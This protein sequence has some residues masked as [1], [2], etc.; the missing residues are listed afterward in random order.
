MWPWTLTPPHAPR[1]SSNSSELFEDDALR[2]YV[3]R[4]LG[5]SLTG[6]TSEQVIPIPCGSGSNGK[7][8]LINV[9]RATLGD[10][11]HTVPFSTFLHQPAGGSSV[12]NDVASLVGRR[13]VTAGEVDESGRFNEA[14][15]K[16]LSG[17]DV[18]SARFMRAEFFSF[19]PV[20]KLWLCVD[21]KPIVEL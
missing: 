3:H 12:P 11:A 5:Y 13:F 16:G 15:L 10:L 21:H 17:G 1:G 18:I 7:S 19:R 14:R 8:T 20:C 2:D 4:A 6:D 9:I